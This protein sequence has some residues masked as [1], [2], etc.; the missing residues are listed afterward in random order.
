[1]ANTTTYTDDDYIDIEKFIP[2][3]LDDPGNGISAY[4]KC[5]DKLLDN[6]EKSDS[7]NLQ[8][9]SDDDDPDTVILV[10]ENVRSDEEIEKEI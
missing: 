8:V 9:K 3:N 4:K 5:V 2:S 7:L 10:N 6:K 1:M